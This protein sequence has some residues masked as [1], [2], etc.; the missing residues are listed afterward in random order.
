R[1]LV[2]LEYLEYRRQGVGHIDENQWQT[3]W[4]DLLQAFRQQSS[5]YRHWFNTDLP[6]DL[7][8]ERL[9]WAVRLQRLH[10]APPQWWGDRTDVDW[11]GLR[12]DAAI[13]DRMV[14]AMRPNRV[15]NGSP[16]AGIIGVIIVLA[17]LAF[18]F[19][20]GGGGKT[21]GTTPTTTTVVAAEATP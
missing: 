18:V 11:S 20:G 12:G 13:V 3:A 10:T 9:G 4:S 8:A 2:E 14:D 15:S 21:P 6:E 16:V 19:G 5:R 17:V 7:Y 1:A